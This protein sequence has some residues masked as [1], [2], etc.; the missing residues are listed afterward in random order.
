[1]FISIWK[2]STKVRAGCYPL[3]ENWKTSCECSCRVTLN[4]L[5]FL[6]FCVLLQFDK[7]GARGDYD[8]PDMAKEA[9]GYL[10]TP[11]TLSSLSEDT[12]S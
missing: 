7:P 4:S 11:W 12:V 1:M 2:S 10:H 8:Y 6:S 3:T 5:F 9:G